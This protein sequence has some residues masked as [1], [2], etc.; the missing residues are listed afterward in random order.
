MEVYSDFL[1]SMAMSV[2]FM[3]CFTVLG[4]FWLLFVMLV[5]EDFY[6][7]IWPWGLA[8]VV[9]EDFL[10]LRVTFDSYTS[11]FFLI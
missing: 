10:S 6:F 4:T 7:Y 2:L 5:M 3:V 8:N 1:S 11:C 9:V